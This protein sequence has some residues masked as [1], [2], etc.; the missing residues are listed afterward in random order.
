[1]WAR[2]IFSKLIRSLDAGEPSKILKCISIGTLR[3]RIVDIGK[4]TG[5][6]PGLGSGRR[7]KTK[8]KRQKTKNGWMEV[9]KLE[10][11]MSSCPLFY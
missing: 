4:Q 11:R 8:D 6:Q 2:E 7:Q 10:N 9:S 1:M 5:H 3:L